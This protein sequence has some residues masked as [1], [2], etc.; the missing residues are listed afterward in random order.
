M[1]QP[2]FYGKPD[3]RVKWDNIYSVVSFSSFG[4]PSLRLETVRAVVRMRN[5]G[6]EVREGGKEVFFTDRK[7][8][9]VY[10][11]YSNT[12]CHMWLKRAASYPARQP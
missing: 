1:E 8:Q 11:A 2:A 7:P 12:T 6:D 5:R 10:S 4:H 3:V 9:S